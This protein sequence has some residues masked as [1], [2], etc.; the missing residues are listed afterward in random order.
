MCININNYNVLL[1]NGAEE[2]NTKDSN[3]AALLKSVC[4]NNNVIL[5]I[6]LCKKQNFK[7]NLKKVKF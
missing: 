1:N 2:P 6:N 5:L 3:P 7:F 4:N